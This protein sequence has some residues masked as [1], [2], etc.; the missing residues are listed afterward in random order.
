M[1]ITLPL[2]ATLQNGTLHII[3]TDTN[4]QLE[5]VPYQKDFIEGT[6]VVTF[7]VTHFSDFGFYTIGSSTL[8]AEGEVQNG[9]AVISSFSR[10][11]ESPD[12]GD[13]IHPKWFLAVGLLFAALAF[14][15]HKGKRNIQQQSA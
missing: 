7:T 9:N 5:D 15:L 3:C 10:K 1:T 6:P 11:D 2:T 12:T 8:Y 4:G 13:L 14:F